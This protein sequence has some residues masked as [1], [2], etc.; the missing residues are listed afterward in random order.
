MSQMTP[1]HTNRCALEQ[2]PRDFTVFS[3]EMQAQPLSKPIIR[4]ADT[5][6]GLPADQIDWANPHYSDVH[7]S[8]GDIV[9]PPIAAYSPRRDTSGM[10][11]I[12]TAD[13][14][15]I[16]YKDWVGRQPIVLSHRPTAAS[17][18]ETVVP[19]FGAAVRCGRRNQGG[20]IS[21]FRGGGTRES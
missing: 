16:Y 12:R 13:G 1:I 15:D 9:A 4:Q 7:R 2:G 17:L 19:C 10:G 11:T 6:C 21:P 18:R 3:Q 14:T 5:A 8:G 20:D